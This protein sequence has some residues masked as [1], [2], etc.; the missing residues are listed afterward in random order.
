MLDK[1]KIGILDL[2]TILVPGG[3]LLFL[4]SDRIL[5]YAAS[6][7]KGYPIMSN[8]WILLGVGFAMAYI[9]GHF[10]FF[11]GSFL[12]QEDP[13]LM[14]HSA[15]HIDLRCDVAR[16]HGEAIQHGFL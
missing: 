4:L 10:I 9:L 13:S 2:L 7:W 3:F 15:A 1:L 16:L 5:G 12:D 8:Q 14:N 6:D 11:I